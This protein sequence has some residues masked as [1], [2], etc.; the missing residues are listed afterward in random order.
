MDDVRQPPCVG[1]ETDIEL[2]IVH[3]NFGPGPAK[4]V[5]RAA[6]G[7]RYCYRC[8]RRRPFF[9]IVYAYDCPPEDDYYG[10]WPAVECADG[11]EDGD[12]FPG[13]VRTWEA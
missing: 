7:E 8:R 12:L 6:L 3:I 9:T 10:P 11:H 1:G 13:R 5:M 2:P 4:E